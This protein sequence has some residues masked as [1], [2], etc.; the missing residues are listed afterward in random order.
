[1][2]VGDC[3]QVVGLTLTAMDNRHGVPRAGKLFDDGTTDEAC[4]AKNEHPHAGI[5]VG[6]AA[7]NLRAYSADRGH[8]HAGA[9]SRGT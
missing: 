8:T 4:S 2:N 7:S 3:R 5:V 1:V 9:L 6:V